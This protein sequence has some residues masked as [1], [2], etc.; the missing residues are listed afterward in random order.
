M[1][2]LKHIYSYSSIWAA[3][4]Q[5]DD[6]GK[7]YLFIGT[8]VSGVIVGVVLL[9][10]GQFLYRRL[11]N[12]MSDKSL[13]ESLKPESQQKP[14]RNSVYEDLNLNE[15]DSGD[16]NYQSLLENPESNQVSCESAN[17]AYTDPKTI[18]EEENNYE[19]LN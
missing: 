2:S 7:W 10:F 3:S 8:I 5:M 16:D 13:Q 18:R 1:F 12:K 4:N 11:K 17:S 15:M 6:K 9:G 19:S 14:E